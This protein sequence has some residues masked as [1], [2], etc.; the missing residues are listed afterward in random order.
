MFMLQ[1]EY[2]KTENLLYADIAFTKGYKSTLSSKKKNL[3]HLFAKYKL[4]LNLEKFNSSN[5]DINLQKVTNDTYL[6]I[7][8]GNLSE[9]A[10]KPNKD[11]LTSSL[12]LSFEHTDYSFSTGLTSYENLSGKNSDRYQFILPHYN[13]ATN[14]FQN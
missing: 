13:F 1:N 8:D 14:L 5:L 11:K 7:F 4:D 3:S 6:K 12:N 9:I 2:K 10:I